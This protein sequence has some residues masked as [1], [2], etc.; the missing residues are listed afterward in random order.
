MEFPASGEW[1]ES[2]YFHINKP[3]DYWLCFE[4]GTKD[5]HIKKNEQ[6]FISCLHYSTLSGT[7]YSGSEVWDEG[8]RNNNYIFLERLWLLCFWREN[9]VVN[10]ACKLCSPVTVNEVPFL[11][12]RMKFDL[13]S[14]P[15]Y[16]LWSNTASSEFRETYLNWSVQ[17]LQLCEYQ[18]ATL[19]SPLVQCMASNI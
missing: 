18:S 7:E 13:H 3:S 4:K 14:W 10:P 2:T 6:F 1:V 16:F 19:R 9:R 11:V 12:K 8:W 5:W 15:M 17:T